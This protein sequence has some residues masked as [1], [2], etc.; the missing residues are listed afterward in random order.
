MV[1]VDMGSWLSWARAAIALGAGITEHRR[2]TA[3][4]R[5]IPA[6]G[7]LKSR[8]RSMGHLQVDLFVFMFGPINRATLQIS[9]E[10][11]G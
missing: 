4:V 2:A 7:L 6:Y 9:S 8:S 3:K 5:R 10:S 11:L 1:P